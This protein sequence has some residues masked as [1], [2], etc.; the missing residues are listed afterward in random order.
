MQARDRYS[1]SPSIRVTRTAQLRELMRDG[2]M[3][4]DLRHGAA[5]ASAVVDNL[6]AQLP[7]AVAL[8]AAFHAQARAPAGLHFAA[9]AARGID[10]E[11]SGDC[12]RSQATALSE[13]LVRQALPGQSLD[14]VLLYGDESD[15]EQAMVKALQQALGGSTVRLIFALAQA[16]EPRHTTWPGRL[17]PGL[18]PNAV[19]LGLPPTAEDAAQLV[20]LA[21][22]QWLLPIEWLST[23]P[24]ASPLEYDRLAATPQ[25]PVRLLALAQMHGSNHFV[26]TNLLVRQAWSEYEQ[27]AKDLAFAMLARAQQLTRDPVRQA[28]AQCHLQGMR[29]ADLRFSQ[30]ADEPPPSTRLPEAVRSFLLLAKGWGCVLEGRAAE[31]ELFLEQGQQLGAYACGSREKHYIDN[32]RA[33][34]RFRQG[35]VTGAL[36]LEEH[37]ASALGDSSDDGQLIFVNGLNLARLRKARG[38]PAQSRRQYQRA[39]DTSY[40]VY[41]DTELLYMHV[42][43]ARCLQSEGDL[44]GAH[45]EWLRSALYWLSDPGR[46]TLSRRVAAIVGGRPWVDAESAARSVS[47]TLLRGLQ[48]GCLGSGAP[49]ANGVLRLLRV[50]QPQVDLG[51]TLHHRA[52]ITVLA[53]GRLPALA[54]VADADD[55]ILRL[56]DVTAA[57]LNDCI[58][59]VLWA[60]GPILGLPMRSGFAVPWTDL[61]A[62]A[63]GLRLG[64]ARARIG[65]RV[66]ELPP[67]V[68]PTWL[69]RANPAVCAFDGDRHG[70][71]VRFRRHRGPVWLEGRDAEVLVQLRAGQPM[72]QRA[73]AQRL[74]LHADAVLALLRR[75][76]TLGLVEMLLQESP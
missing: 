4:I 1:A 8:K 55:S 62:L 20:A 71:E 25:L 50:Y 76:E 37:I 52:G 43:F 29:I 44:A 26:D 11:L 51:C 56:A 68:Q 40:G 72:Q 47:N 42:C 54:E 15:A 66:I 36:A 18:V 63:E 33:L 65:G 46:L 6:A 48:A 21:Q 16:A 5:S 45:L 60:D 58:G 53:G 32:I 22:G 61:A 27:G 59:D 57:A 28:I 73:M 34:A 19:L 7:P 24:L 75:L 10:A 41:T 74:D 39:F 23:R 31:G 12:T 49:P 35:D 38:E 30:A 17:I 3:V 9:A 13:V 69:V 67:L 2:A 70:L 64:V 14:V